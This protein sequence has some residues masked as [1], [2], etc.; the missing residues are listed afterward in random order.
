LCEAAIPLRDG[1][2]LAEIVPADD[3][4]DPLDPAAAVSREPV[5]LGAPEVIRGEVRRDEHVVQV[6]GDAPRREEDLDG[7]R[8]GEA[9]ARRGISPG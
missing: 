9:D 6:D 8:G 3:A 5:R 2:D 4:V 1:D 7:N